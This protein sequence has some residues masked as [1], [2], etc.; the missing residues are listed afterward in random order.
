MGLLELESWFPISQSFPFLGLDGESEDDVLLLLM[1][2][3]ILAIAYT[4]RGY[5][6]D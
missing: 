2:M 3:I 4:F 1:I 5:Y 6:K